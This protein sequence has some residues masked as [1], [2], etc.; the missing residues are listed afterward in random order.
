MEAALGLKVMD[1][2]STVTAKS[3]PIPTIALKQKVYES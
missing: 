1:L 2:D 3:E